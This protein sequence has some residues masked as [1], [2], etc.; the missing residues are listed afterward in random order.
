MKHVRLIALSFLIVTSASA[1]TVYVPSGTGGIGSSANSNVGIGTT[2]A[3]VAKLEVAGGGGNTV[4]IKVN[5]RL[6]TG[7]DGGNLG[8]M[9]VGSSM[10][11]GQYGPTMIGL[12][13]N[14]AWRLLIDNNGNVGIGT[15]APGSF[16]LA[17]EGKIGAREV[18]I[19]S[20]TP[21]PD[22]VFTPNHKLPSLETIE[23]YIQKHKHLPEVPTAKEVEAKGIDLGQMNTILLKK[24]EELTLYVIELKKE[25][26]QLKAKK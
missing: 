18:T 25:V 3:P 26:D 23:R 19:T 2:S 13:N 9:W 15:T 17:V 14:T 20:T 24:V 6:Q 22:Y 1:Q 12:Y 8:G 5:G 21:W 10:F 7:A 4:D 16:K 11:M